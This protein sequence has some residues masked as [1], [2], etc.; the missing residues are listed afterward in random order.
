MIRWPGTILVATAPVN[1]H[2][3]FDRLAAIVREQLGAD[4]RS[5]T[6]IVFH[7]RARTHVKLL[8]HDG[9]GYCLFYKRLDR[10]TYR[11][12][13]AIPPGARQVSVSAREL[14][15]VLEGIDEAAL[16]AARRSV[17]PRAESSSRSNLS[18]SDHGTLRACE[19]VLSVHSS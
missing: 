10:G 12:P 18:K 6:L 16:R 3:S 4:P 7:N 15:L 2:L 8:W 14:A 5:D 13:L 19:G 1:L 9:R 11:I 17:L